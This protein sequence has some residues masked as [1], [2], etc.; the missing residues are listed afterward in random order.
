LRSSAARIGVGSILGVLAVA[1]AAATISAQSRIVTEVDTAR[2]TVGDR[3]ALT[4]S[5]EHRPDTRVEWPDSLDLAPFEVL[6]VRYHAPS[7]SRGIVRSSA[8]LTLAAFE[9][10]ALEI[11]PFEVAVVGRGGEREVLA[12]DPIAVEVVSV[13]ADESGDIRDI[14]GPLAIPLALWRV[15]LWT[16]LPMLA[17]ALLY[18]LARRLRAREDAT[19]RPALAMP[20]RPAHELALEALAELEA[21]PLLA[22]GE[23]KEYHIRV[24]DILRRYLERRF[25]VDALEMTTTEVL[26]ALAAR[27]VEQNFVD[28]LR[29]FLEQC[30]LVKF[31]KACPSPSVCRQVLELGRR[32]VV[33]SA[34][35]P[36]PAAGPLHGDAASDRS[37]V[38]AG[39]REAAPAWTEAG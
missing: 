24:A 15:A 18:V 34:P 8:R 29:A 23:I 19:S 16:L 9:L 27:G 12:T 5:V 33:E 17:I 21:S 31:A 4:V 38:A 26:Q 35:R 3:I 28:G 2:V 6:E 32:L 20:E 39:E 14:R 36:G 25:R 11:A 22:R 30:D 13:G 1:A 37:G 7:E 10:G